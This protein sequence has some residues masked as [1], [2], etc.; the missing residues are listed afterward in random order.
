MANPFAPYCADVTGAIEQHR[1]ANMATGQRDQNPPS[2]VQSAKEVLDGEE[3][4]EDVE[5]LT[6]KDFS[7]AAANF[8]VAAPERANVLVSGSPHRLY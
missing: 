6:S 1:L 3:H 7:N 4:R 8:Q 5:E 2:L